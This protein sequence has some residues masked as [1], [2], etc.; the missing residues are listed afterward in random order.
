M[1]LH[2]D[3][4]HPLA[5]INADGSSLSLTIVAANMS[6]EA[7]VESPTTQLCGVDDDKSNTVVKCDNEGTDE[8]GD[9]SAEEKA[10]DANKWEDSKL[11][12]I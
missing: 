4:L 3:F 9:T 8:E 1:R 5:P 11:E 12:P 10:T 6:T 2:I 7:E